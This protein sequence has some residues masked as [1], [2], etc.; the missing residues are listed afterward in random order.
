MPPSE[1]VAS[2]KGLPL[3]SLHPNGVDWERKVA[4]QYVELANNYACLVNWLEDL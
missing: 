2:V 4:K 3:K 1:C